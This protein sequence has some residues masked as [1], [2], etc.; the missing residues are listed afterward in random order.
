VIRAEQI[1]RARLYLGDCRDFRSICDIDAIITDP[2][3]GIGYKVNERRYSTR[4]SGLKSTGWTATAA[5]PAILG[6]EDLFDPAPWLAK[7][8]PTALFGAQHF[9]DR[10]PLGRWLVWD[11]RR[12]SKPDSHS[13]ADLVWL[14]G[15]NRQALRVHR[16][17]WRGIV[18]EGEENASRSRKLHPNQKPVALL[19]LIIERLGLQPGQTVLDPF[20]GS[21]STGVAALRMGLNFVGCEID[22]EHFET[23]RLRLATG[24]P[25]GR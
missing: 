18:R 25:D 22:A 13:D 19:T 12:E 16:Q 8:V 23:A 3:Y 5:V 20:M 24:G 9:S 14:T 21:G 15:D 6:D 4:Y 2:P 1:G 10:L 7:G 17:K 11:K